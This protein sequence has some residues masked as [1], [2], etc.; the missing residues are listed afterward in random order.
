MVCV[1]AGGLLVNVVMLRLLS[2]GRRESL[3]V[4]G[5]WL[6]VL[7]DLL[8]SVGAVASG[9]LIWWLGWRW[10]DPIASVLIAL[11]VIGSGLSLLRRTATVLMEGTPTHIDTDAVQHCM[12]RLPAVCSVH[13]LHVWTITGGLEALSAH[14]VIERGCDHDSLLERIRQTL[15]QEFR[16][17]HVT[18]QFEHQHCGDEH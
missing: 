4:E 14:V 8:G 1:A 2:G 13:H 9:V 10:V 15:R 7:S 12:Q 16:I 17:E 5:A 11:L 6:H 18:I 3:N